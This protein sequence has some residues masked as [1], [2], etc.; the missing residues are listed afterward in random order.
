MGTGIGTIG[1]PARPADYQ[2]IDALLTGAFGQTDEARLVRQ[3]RADGDMWL[4]L[5]ARNEGVIAGYVALS[6]MQSPGGWACLGPLAVHPRFR[7]GATAPSPDQR[8]AFRIGTPLVRECVDALGTEGQPTTLVV[9][10]EPG[11]YERAGFSRERARNLTT[12]YPSSHTL[13]ARAGN[14]VPDE[15]VVYPRAFAAPG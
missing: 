12:P 2:E 11:F 9:L 3:L 6:R 5:V 15:I 1:Q 7:N 8:D 4:E 10:G 13:I 14:D